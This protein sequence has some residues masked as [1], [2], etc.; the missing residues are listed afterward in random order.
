[1][2]SSDMTPAMLHAC[3]IVGVVRTAP[4]D[5]RDGVRWLNAGHSAAL[6]GDSFEHVRDAALRLAPMGS[7]GAPGN[8]AVH[9]TGLQQEAHYEWLLVAENFISCSAHAADDG[10]VIHVWSG[11]S[12]DME[13]MA[14]L[15]AATGIPAAR[16]SLHSLEGTADG[17][18]AAQAACA[19]VELMRACGQPVSVDGFWVFAQPGTATVSVGATLDQGGSLLEWAYVARTTDSSPGVPANEP[20]LY[21]SFFTSTR[22]DH[23]AGIIPPLAHTFARESFIDEIARKNERDPLAFR[24]D[25]LDPVSDGGARDLIRSV[26]ERAVWQPIEKARKPGFSGRGRGFAFDKPESDTPEIPAYSAWIV[27]LDVDR[28]T[29]DVAIRRVVAGRAS[30]R[31]GLASLSGLPARQIADAVSNAMGLRLSAHPSHDETAGEQALSHELAAVPQQAGEVAP[32]PSG[33]D[34]MQASSPAVA[35]IANALYDA[36]GV[37]FR[38]PP[39]TP[40]RVRATLGAAGIPA[41]ARRSIW[42]VLAAGG[43]GGLIGLACSVWPSRAPIAPIERPASSTWSAAT[44]ARGRSIAAAAD[45]AVCHTVPG[46]ASNA[47]G[48][49]LATPFGTVYT[50][51]LTPDEKT[52]IG[53]WS[54]AAFNRALRE[55]ISRDGR[56]LYPAFP[57]TAFTKM[58]EADMTALYAYLMSQP[59]VASVVPETRL[60]FPLNQRGLVAGWNAL[61]LKQ[62]EFKPDPARS[63]EWNRGA[64]LVDGV[65]HCSACHSPRNA[66]GAERGGRLYLGGGE[67]EGW[68]APSLVASSRAPVKWTEQAL[69]DYLKSGFSPEHGVAA[70]PMAPVVAG[71]STLPEAD[72]RAIA[73]YIASLSPAVPASAV[74]T[75]QQANEAHAIRVQGL[76]HGRRIF[77]G[78][79]AVC[80]SATGGVGNFGVRPLMSLNTS[81]SETTPDNLLHVIQHGIDAPATDALGYM[82][83]FKESFDDR[84]I[85][86][87]AAYIRARFA[88][89]EAPWKD[90]ARASARVR[91]ISQ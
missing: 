47:G 70:G 20:G 34:A 39:F 63:A 3:V 15:S 90:L 57:Y 26:A 85:A 32:A 16:F 38:A 35:A 84:Q 29:G 72:V 68:V 41:R 53:N 91:S 13:L 89:G 62:G 86:D 14:S 66:L 75:P 46:G 51:N 11:V 69:F 36:T 25:H 24:I 1:M 56:H 7:D 19:A 9:R 6:V 37:R 55:G 71:L 30:G 31:R 52:G 58:S 18:L 33:V 40:E 2:P 12:D 73:H 54:F 67:A 81:V 76:D 49:G 79:C 88:P 77:E 44:I 87:L 8:V 65:G 4:P 78:A 82:P 43:I 45:C 42:K 22:I 5:L 28:T 50:T 80:H 23:S 21:Q 10:S 74:I 83:S 48:L 64:Y 59:A 17:T 27:D 61:Y 60:P